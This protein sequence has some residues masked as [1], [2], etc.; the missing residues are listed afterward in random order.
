MWLVWYSRWKGFFKKCESGK[1][2]GSVEEKSR[3]AK[4]EAIQ[5]GVSERK[6][7]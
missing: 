3:V 7:A 5:R 6:P 1:S 2:R 4:A